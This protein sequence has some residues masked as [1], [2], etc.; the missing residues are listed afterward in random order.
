MLSAEDTLKLNVLIDTCATIRVD[1]YKLIVVGL[2]SEQKEQTIALSTDT[3]SGETIVAVQKLLISQVLG[4]MGGYLSYL[5][6]W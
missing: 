1:S 3:D 2:T 6:R 4:S 5:K